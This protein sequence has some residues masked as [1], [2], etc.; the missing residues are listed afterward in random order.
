MSA[1][2]RSFWLI[3][4]VVVLLWIAGMSF[5]LAMSPRLR[6]RARAGGRLI[7]P[8]L[9]GFPVAAVG[10]LLSWKYFD[11]SVLPVLPGMAIFVVPVQRHRARLADSQITGDPQ[12]L[13]PA[14]RRYVAGPAPTDLLRH[15]V[16]TTRRNL[17][18]IRASLSPAGRRAEK[19][20][21]REQGLR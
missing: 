19:Q 18:I 7:W 11:G 13:S 16:A 4:A 6:R 12:N 17:E 5:G 1:F 8:V 2:L 10:A 9:T 21:E 3:W 20:W 15:P 14:V